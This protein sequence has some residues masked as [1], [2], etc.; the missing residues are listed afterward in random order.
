MNRTRLHRLARP[1]LVRRARRAV[2][3][4][5]KAASSRC[6]GFPF[7]VAASRGA[8]DAAGR[9]AQRTERAYWY[10]RKLL[11]FT[12]RFRLLVLSRHDWPKYAEVA[13]VRHRALHGRWSPRRRQRAG[14]RV[15]RR[16]PRARALPARARACAMSATCTA[17]DPF[18]R[19]APDLGGV[20]EA[21]MAHELARIVADQARATFPLPWLKDAFANYA[22]VAVLGET[23]PAALHRIGTLAEAAR[24]LAPITPPVDGP[25]RGRTLH[26]VSCRARP[27]CAH[28]RRVRRVRG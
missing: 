2:L 21:L 12:P 16:E 26:A 3:P 7:T 11:R 20:A 18:H 19:D 6:R 27:A 22:L 13:D 24:E 4:G 25:R 10:L 23:D 17:R 1:D 15:A 9:I 8:V 14:R 5:R 28:A